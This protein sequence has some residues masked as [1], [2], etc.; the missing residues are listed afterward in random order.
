MDERSR[1]GHPQHGRQDRR[2][3]GCERCEH[4]ALANGHARGARIDLQPYLIGQGHGCNVA[5]HC[6]IATMSIGSDV[7]QAI[8]PA[9]IAAALLA[10]VLGDVTRARL[11]RFAGRQEL[12]ITPVNAGLV[13]GYLASIRRWRVSG[14]LTGALIEGACTFTQNDPT[15][16]FAA[17]LGPG[18]LIGWFVGALVAE[19]RIA[20]R[21]PTG[22]R[23]SAS[24]ATRR[25]GDYLPTWFI[26]SSGALWLVAAGTA[27]ASVVR[28]DATAS[29]LAVLAA[30]LL[31]APVSAVVMRRVVH[32]PQPMARPDVLSAD[33][34]LR[35]R[36]LH[37][38]AGCTIA[39]DGILLA[40]ALDP[41]E[42]S[43]TASVLLVATGLVGGL[44]MPIF[45]WFAATSP[46]AA[47]RTTS[48]AYRERAA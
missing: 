22:A 38:L 4:Q 45:G 14:Y 15:H 17:A 23:R 5:G 33:D 34:A 20:S 30:A 1:R 18:A 21:R 35:S 28:A 26:I 12:L 27:C 41:F 48:V 8:I 39:L 43:G 24:L 40:L 36:S 9:L 29:S 37:V 25:L 2:A 44:L 3:D 42:S 13:I 6:Y 46:F 47:R 19:W 32:R 11:E 10:S 31:V 7:V 16:V